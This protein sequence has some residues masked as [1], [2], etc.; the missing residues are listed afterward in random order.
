MIVRTEDERQKAERN[1]HA[2]LAHARIN[3]EAEI[4]TLDA[5]ERV[6]SL[7]GPALVKTRNSRANIFGRIV[8]F[9]KDFSVE[10]YTEAEHLRINAII[11]ELSKDASLV[12]LGLR[13]CEAGKEKRYATDLID[14][15]KKL[16]LTIMV[17]GQGD[18]NL[19]K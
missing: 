1:F 9:L 14:L 17:K 6:Q 3:A 7:N 15:L 12:V 5:V 4:M 18:V 19:F 11:A 13:L 8:A 10:T 16:P 2:I